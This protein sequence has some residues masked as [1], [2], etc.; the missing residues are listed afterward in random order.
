MMIMKIVSINDGNDN[1]K[2]GV[3]KAN[4]MKNEIMKKWKHEVNEMMAAIKSMK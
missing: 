2:S 3:M 4:E 1:Q